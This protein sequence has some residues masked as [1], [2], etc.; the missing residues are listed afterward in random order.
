ML[1]FAPALANVTILADA[2]G[3]LNIAVEQGKSVVID[4]VVFQDLVSEMSSLRAANR[5]ILAKVDQM[6]LAPGIIWESHF[7]RFFP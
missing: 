3:N 6:R 7:P 5:E 4:G 2:A 1:Y